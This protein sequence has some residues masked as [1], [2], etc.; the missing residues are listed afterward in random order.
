MR[1]SAILAAVAALALAGCGNGSTDEASADQVAADQV[2]AEEQTAEPE[3]TYVDQ[4]KEAAQNLSYG[5]MSLPR[6]RTITDFLSPEYVYSMGTNARR[7]YDEDIDDAQIL[8]SNYLFLTP[9]SEYDG[10][11]FANA[12][13][14][15]IDPA[16]EWNNDGSINSVM[17]DVLASNKSPARFREAFSRYC[18]GELSV[19]NSSAVIIGTVSGPY[20]ECKFMTDSPTY[21][22]IVV[23]IDY[24]R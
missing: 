17:G 13:G 9:Y 24:K 19:D 8:S 20:A 14:Y 22:E 10:K 1:K 11:P 5:A 6:F 18:Q 7:M 12:A 2:A 21:S 23:T 15:I 16:I 3:K 4:K